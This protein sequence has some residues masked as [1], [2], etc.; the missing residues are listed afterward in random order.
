MEAAKI[1]VASRKGLEDLH[2]LKQTI[3]GK[4]SMGHSNAVGL[5]GVTLAIIVIADFWIVEIANLSLNPVRSSGR[6]RVATSVHC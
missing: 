6:E 5:H 1:P 3:V 4:Q 2:V